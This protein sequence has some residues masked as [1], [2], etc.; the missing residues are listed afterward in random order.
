M[1]FCTFKKITK[2]KRSIIAAILLFIFML[3]ISGMVYASSY[4]TYVSFTNPYVGTVRSF[5]GNNIRYCATMKS[6]KSN[7]TGTY[8][9]TLQRKS[10]IWAQD[11]GSKTL[12]R[13]GYGEA[14]WSNVGSGKYRLSFYKSSDGVTLSSSKVLFENY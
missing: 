9:I 3:S 7:D 10:G 1:K 11:V 13:V 14:K 5:N 8:E 12:K 2:E 6:S 4:T